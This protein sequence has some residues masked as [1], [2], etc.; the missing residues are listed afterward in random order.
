MW[1]SVLA[2]P[3]W[4]HQIVRALPETATLAR[5]VLLF[6]K[7]RIHF[8][9][10]EEAQICMNGCT[11]ATSGDVCTQNEK[12][13]LIPCVLSRR[14][15]LITFMRSRCPT[16]SPYPWSLDLCPPHTHTHRSQD[17][18]PLDYF[19]LGVLERE[20]NSSSYS[21]KETLKLLQYQGDT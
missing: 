14:T 16:C 20:V 3:Y 15:R 8:V 12:P 5:S 7:P 11:Q 18:H 9:G 4:S 13:A 21:T 10:V 17:C 2:V 19:V 6:S 1:P